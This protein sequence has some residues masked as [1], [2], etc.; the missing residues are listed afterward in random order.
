MNDLTGPDG[1]KTGGGLN[2]PTI[3]G[4]SL[5]GGGGYAFLMLTN[6]HCCAQ[7]GWSYGV[8]VSAD[9][10]S[11]TPAVEGGAL[12]SSVASDGE[13]TV[14]AGHLGRG[15]DATFWIGSAD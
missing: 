6:N 7:M 13:T 1:P 11:W 12:V 10:N 5:A 14:L 3:G 4:A 15:E 2:D 8:W 9:G